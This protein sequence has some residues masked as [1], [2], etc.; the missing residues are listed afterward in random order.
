[1]TRDARAFIDACPVCACGKSSHQP[2]AGLLHPLP[3]PRRPW[4]HITV[5][6]VTGLPTSDGQRV[7]LT[8]DDRFSKAAHFV[9]LSKIPTAA[10]TRG[11]VVKHVFSLHG[12]PTRHHLQ[13]GSTVY[14]AQ[15]PANLPTQFRGSWMCTSGTVAGSTWWTGRGTVQRIGSGFLTNTSWTGASNRPPARTTLTSQV[16]TPSDTH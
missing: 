15:R 3:V 1:M 10:E 14:Q 8:I 4:S 9:P 6:F 16:K 5:N 12:I 11:L 7:I 2:P 13:S